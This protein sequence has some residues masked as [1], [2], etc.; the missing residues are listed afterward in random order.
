MI[1]KIL[2]ANRG[3]IALRIIRACREL[4][5]LSVAIYS[6]ADRDSLHV[7]FADEAVCVGLAPSADSY[8]NVSRIISAAEISNADA[9]HPGYGFLAENT[10]FAEIC[11]SND[12]IFIGPSA[13]VIGEMGNKAK[14]KETMMKAGLQVI[15]GSKGI[16]KDAN[17]AEKIANDIGFPVLLKAVSGGGGKGMRVVFHADEVK[18]QFPIAQNEAEINFGDGSIYLEKFFKNPRHIEIQILGDNF[19]NIIHLGERDCSIQRRHQKLIE[20]SPSPAL[21]QEIRNKMG[22]A[23]VKGAEFVNY[24]NAGTIEFLFSEDGT[25]YFM[26]MNTRIQVEHPVTEMVCSMD[27]V[28][29][30]IRIA[31]GEKMTLKQDDV[32]FAGYAIECRINAED[33]EKNFVPSPGKI[34]GFHLPGGPGIRIDTHVYASYVVPPN[35]DSL[36]AKL[37]THG[38]T[39]EEALLRMSRALNEFIVEGIHTTIPFHQ[40]VISNEKFKQGN[41][42]T[43]F[44]EEIKN[45][46]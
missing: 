45:G 42:H 25:F 18:K 35:Y 20:E 1:S 3:E 46:N 39:R 17:E 8:L 16:V 44:L 14:A 31:S 7:R 10:A 36:L 37:I 27:L 15:P 26:E 30:Q 40:M 11:E 5:V 34:T 43:G 24:S 22:A 12:I 9:I 2:I 29:E 28:K 38:N 4:G 19:G 13:K 23:A 33:S 32:N 6:E 21:S 41:Y